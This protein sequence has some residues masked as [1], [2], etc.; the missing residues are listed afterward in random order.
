MNFNK[1]NENWEE[2]TLY[3]IANWKNGLAFKNIQF[4]ATGIPIIKIAELKNGITAQTKFTQ[5]KF[6][7]DVSLKKEDLIFSWSGNPETSIDAF[8]YKINDGYLN[9]HS[10]KVTPI[11]KID[12]YFFY[13]ILKY[14]KPIFVKIASNKQTTGLGHVTIGNLKEI[15]VRFPVLE[16]QI[17]ILSI[18]KTLD[19]KIE[20]NNQ[21]NNNLSEI[22]IT[23]FNNFIE[24]HS[25]YEDVEL[26]E[27]VE[28]IGT[29]ADA[30][31]RAPIVDYN[32]G[33]RCIRIGDMT[34]QRTR[35]NWGFTKMT[36]KDF[37]NYK[38]KI[39]DIVITRTAVNG[40]SYIIDDDMKVVCNNGL[41]RLTVN[42]QFNPLYVYMN[43][44]TKR[45]D[46]YIRRIEGETSVRPNMKVNYLT[47]Y[48][49]K[50]IPLE[51]Q[52]E[53]CKKL[54]PMRNKQNEINYENEN[55]IKLRD[56]LLPKLMN[57]EI[58]LENLEI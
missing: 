36:E 18:L 15:K 52:N 28:K 19:D 30:I 10:F 58:D 41:I 55:L 47:A 34:N 53:F 43:M 26:L 39:G 56:I 9:Q 44:K 48:K 54:I 4:S 51:I 12:K 20:K 31:Q 33:I 35:Y 14:L 40:L 16:K 45:F 24:E 29:G 57:G 3:E 23:M 8:L 5:Q 13:Y 42:K 37:E 2:Y 11:A 17:K 49:I 1:F 46:D 27:T 50:N 38:L 32:T 21:I 6:S 25:N 7:D 22:I